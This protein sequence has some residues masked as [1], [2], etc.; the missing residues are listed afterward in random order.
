MVESWRGG[1]PTRQSLTPPLT[2]TRRNSHSPRREMDAVMP[3]LGWGGTGKGA[4]LS[5]FKASM[6]VNSLTEIATKAS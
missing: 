3:T 6:S 5:Y 4:N 1:R 2:H